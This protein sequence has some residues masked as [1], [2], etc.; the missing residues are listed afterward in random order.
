MGGVRQAMGGVLGDRDATQS[1][2]LLVELVGSVV[3][4]VRHAPWA[5]W[6]MMAPSSVALLTRELWTPGGG[7]ICANRTHPS[8]FSSYQYILK[9]R[10]LCKSDGCS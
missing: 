1:C 5:L 2:A 3:T 4:P 8:I 6:R 10:V 9:R 7:E